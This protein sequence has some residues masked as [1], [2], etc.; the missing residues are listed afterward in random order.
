ML[1]Y[2][3]NLKGSLTYTTVSQRQVKIE[4]F[5]LVSTLRDSFRLKLPSKTSIWYLLNSVRGLESIY[6]YLDHLYLQYCFCTVK[7]N[8]IT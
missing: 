6:I 1:I 4:M 8:S 2:T 3:S 5:F 7:K